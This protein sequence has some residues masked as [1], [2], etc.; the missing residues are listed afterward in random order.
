MGESLVF[1]DWLRRRR[2]ALDLTREKLAFRVGCSFET[3]KKI[4]LGDLKPS[5]QLAELLATKLE[6]PLAEHRAFVQFARS[7]TRMDAYAFTQLP[8]AATA[9][10]VPSTLP[11]P[12]TS[13]LGRAREI[14]AALKLLE[15]SDVRLLTL[16]GPP[17]SGKTRLSLAIAAHARAELS[18]HFIPLAPVSNAALV[19]TAVAKGLDVQE[20]KNRP[21][22]ETLRNV[23]RQQHLLIVLD[24]FEQVMDAAPQVSEWLAAAPQVKFIVT[25]RE[26]LRI[27][28][29]HLLPVPPLELPDV[30]HLPPIEALR[31]YAAVELFVGRAQAVRP[32]FGLT[33]E[34]ATTV[35][36]IC[37][38]L[39]GLPL[40]IEMAAAQIRRDSPQRVLARLNERLVGLTGGMRDLTPR[41][42]TL[43]GAIDWSYDLLS[44]SEM[45]LLNHLG[46]FVGGCD[47][48]AIRATL[49]AA[50]A[51]LPDVL[52]S[53][54]D[55]LTDKNLVKSDGE[56]RYWLLEMIGDYAREKLLARGV[57]D[58]TQRAHADYFASWAEQVNG[59]AQTDAGQFQRL[60]REPDNLRA[61]LEWAL[62]QPDGVQALRLCGA[63][64][65][66]WVARGY[67]SEGLSWTRRALAQQKAEELS[68][69]KLRLYANALHV[70][71]QLAER[72]ESNATTWGF[73][74]ESLRLRRSL[75]EPSAIIESLI[76]LSLFSYFDSQ[77]ETGVKYG[78]EGLALC[79]A[80]GNQ[81]GSAFLLNHL[82]RLALARDDYSSAQKYLHESLAT[83]RALQ[84]KTNLAM[85]LHNLGVAAIIGGR[86]AEARTHFAESLELRVSLS[87]LRGIVQSYKMM[88]VVAYHVGEYA[89]AQAWFDKSVASAR[90]LNDR[91]GEAHALINLGFVAFVEGN[92]GLTRTYIAS[93][94]EVAHALG[95]KTIPQLLALELLARLALAEG[96]YASA[97]AHATLG[98]TE[99]TTLHS[100]EEMAECARVLGYVALVEGDL[101][102]ARVYFGQER[103]L[104]EVSGNARFTTK[105]YN[106][107][108]YCE[109]K[110][111]HLDDA[112]A[113]YRTSLAWARRAEDRRRIAIA[114]LGL[115]GVALARQDAVHATRLVSASAKLREA[116][117]VSLLSLPK[118]MRDDYLGY[119]AKA[120]LQLDAEQFDAA[121]EEGLRDTL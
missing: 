75:G 72:Q 47:L 7:E 4:E 119:E 89:E 74:E 64:G 24:N 100:F 41:Q 22:A 120:R 73:Y 76:T 115:A 94:Q 9:P 106:D 62:A 39:D 12:P 54:L 107:L 78:E 80:T 93:T 35:A 32:D 45:Q 88:G 50:E 121:W 57:L 16:T 67:W 11:T 56:G 25:S 37:A 26:A 109:L 104:Q 101:A 113:F 19:A 5:A 2:K 91:Y 44:A 66:F 85:A 38:L 68:R 102:T 42:Q 99:W 105:A 36:R 90:A 65:P 14:H 86:H 23:L 48:A 79:R 46:V 40:A 1:G 114:L 118:P 82:G 18:V 28:G 58:A 83:S 10:P 112:E 98:L 84:D 27:Y 49:P 43:R 33:P 3:I 59:A 20:E 116:G 30:H 97:R 21:L 8:V 53:D 15:R 69:D 70:A 95:D 52:Q 51:E 6:V 63:F 77:T 117:T 60:E 55:S 96:D 71:G 17:G 103:E 81:R 110:W 13:L 92:L 111:N 87:D 29:E 108:G 34:N 61:A 31:H